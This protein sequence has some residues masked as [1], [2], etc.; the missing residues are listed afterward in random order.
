MHV[1]LFDVDFLVVVRLGA[2]FIAFGAPAS[3]IRTCV[4]ASPCVVL[5]SCQNMAFDKTQR[6][7]GPFESQKVLIKQ[8]STII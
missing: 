2:G 7:Q 8:S 4:Y 1:C 5:V 6:G 3:A